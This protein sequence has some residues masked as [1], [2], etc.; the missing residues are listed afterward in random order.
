MTFDINKYNG[1]YLAKIFLLIILLHSLTLFSGLIDKLMHKDIF[2]RGTSKVSFDPTKS[3]VE[4]QT[5][6]KESVTIKT[7]LNSDSLTQKNKLTQRE[8]NAQEEQIDGKIAQTYMGEVLRLIERAKYYPVR[9]KM[10]GNE[11][12]PVVSMVIDQAGN[13][14]DA[15]I[16]KESGFKTLDKAAI[17]IVKKAAPYPD[18]HPEMKSDRFSFSV[19]IEFKLDR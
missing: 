3:L 8:Q 15:K 10:Y 19:S 9:D 5:Y 2:S 16:L 1:D 17:D 6:I 4:K 11:G 12:S 7:F 14:L 18:F 13:L